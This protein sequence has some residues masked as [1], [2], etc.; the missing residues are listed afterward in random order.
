MMNSKD[1]LLLLS[2]IMFLISWGCA[3]QT[4]NIQPIG[5]YCGV[6]GKEYVN[7]FAIENLD[8]EVF[9][10][11]ST[12]PEQ[13]YKAESLNILVKSSTSDD[14]YV[15]YDH[16]QV[17][18]DDE[19]ISTTSFLKNCA[20]GITPESVGAFEATLPVSITLK[21]DYT[22]TAEKA[23]T[24]QIKYGSEFSP[25]GFLI[26]SVEDAS[27]PTPSSSLDFDFSEYV[28]LEQI[29]KLSKS[30]KA[31]KAKPETALDQI[32]M[33]I[34]VSDNPS[35]YARINLRKVKAPESQEPNP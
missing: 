14:Q 21:S 34:K 28:F 13:T 31:L 2:P 5:T 24:Y 1:L 12:L 15:R 18:A 26:G 22:W 29:G 17:F 3:R 27:G 7:P 35:I 4:N 9:S 33:Q 32:F 20:R 11:L 10:E 23:V 25:Q 16:R 19:S 30:Q 8:V 6:S